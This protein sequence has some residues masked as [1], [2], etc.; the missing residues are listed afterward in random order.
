[1]GRIYTATLSAIAVTAIQDLWEI[2]APSD[3]VVILHS[4]EIGQNTDFGDAEAEGLPVQISRATGTAGSGGA[5]V[6]P[7]PLE[8]GDA[9]YGGTVERNNTTQAGTTTVIHTEVFNIQGGWLYLPPPEK[10]IVISPSG[11]LVIELPVAPT[12][13][14]TVYSTITFEEIGG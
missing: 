10:R 13:S 4:C 7:T 3:A 1:M 9:A 5:S 14:I 12:D 2:N 11:V 6:T 8:V